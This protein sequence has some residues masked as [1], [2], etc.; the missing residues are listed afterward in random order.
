M[1]RRHTGL[2][3]A[4]TERPIA[5]W[6]D[7]FI[8]GLMKGAM[9]KRNTKSASSSP[10]QFFEK[11]L[12]GETPPSFP[13]M[14]KLYG[15]A[16]ELYTLR[17]WHL[18]NENQLVLVRDSATG[19]TC[20]CSVM[21]RL[22]EVLA[23]HAYRGSE[24]Y[25]LFR[26]I[27][28]GE[29]ISPSEFL[30]AQHSVYVDFVPMAE[31][32]VQDRKALKA[33]GHPRAAQ[34]GPM[35]RAIRPGYHPWFVTEEEAQTLIECA[36]AM[37]FICSMVSRQGALNYW[38]QQ[39]VYPL[40][41]P[42]EGS[43]RKASPPE[44]SKVRREE[45]WPRYH[46]ELVKAPKPSEKPLSPVPLSQEQLHQLR[47]R[48]H[49]VGGAIELDH[50]QSRMTIGKKNERKACVAIGM[51]VDAKTGMVFPPEVVA[52]GVSAGEALVNTLMKAIE[53]YRA[54]PQEVRVKSSGF[55]ECLQPISEIC[56]FSVEVVRSLPG[57]ERARSEM[58]RMMGG[59]GP[60]Q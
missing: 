57:L 48:D 55:K 18:L 11:E 9:P 47:D 52:P 44:V 49:T 15:L 33:L 4:A 19:E 42:I 2:Q 34:V 31:L 3:R 8:K 40:L 21:G 56:G 13:T 12:S 25:R 58:I 54:L 51:A 36:C 6:R 26:Q 7:V 17:P 5:P 22:G 27:E 43:P 29:A 16:T 53:T 38:D 20:Y 41:S 30:A 45:T 32:D 39:D 14:E 24:G 50:F 23:M 10:S 37:L 35:F 1:K 60:F 46:V 28:D 59:G